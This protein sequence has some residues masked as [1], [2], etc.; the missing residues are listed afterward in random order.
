MRISYYNWTNFTPTQN[1]QNYNDTERTTKMNIPR[2]RVWS[3]NDNKYLRINVDDY[4]LVF[5]GDVWQL[6]NN[7]TVAP[8]LANVP[9][10][11]DPNFSSWLQSQL[12][13]N[14]IC[15]ALGNSV[16][17]QYNPN[18]IFEMF[19]GCTDKEGCEIWEG[20]L[21]QHDSGWTS[22]VTYEDGMFVIGRFPL[23]DYVW[24]KDITVRGDRSG[25][26]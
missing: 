7:S 16:G 23:R 15:P 21:I 8:S 18:Y 14:P 9:D 24:A 12:R 4:E 3:V 1:K 26:R 5:R 10:E 11:D 17:N 2:I 19:T 6:K 13:N 20:D 22:P 25:T